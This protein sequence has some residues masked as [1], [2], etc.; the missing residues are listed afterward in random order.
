MT[1]HTGRGMTTRTMMPIHAHSHNI[2]NIGSGPM[3][4]LS[5][6]NDDGVVMPRCH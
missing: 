6:D 1:T 3:A 5:G 4:R 2:V